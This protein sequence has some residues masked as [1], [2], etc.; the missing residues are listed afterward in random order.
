M[1]TPEE[2][3]ALDAAAKSKADPKPDLGKE[4]EALKAKNLEYENKIKEFE[5]RKVDDTDL[6]AKA[7]AERDAKDKKNSD[8]KA[9]EKA[10]TFNL[11]ADEFLKTNE[12]L[13]PKDIGDIFKLAQKENY[14]DAI[15][16]DGAIKT[17][18]IQSFFSVQANMDLLT[19]SQKTS[20]DD[21]L[22]LTKTGKQ[23][24]AQSIYDSIFEPSFE[25]L[26]RI[27]KATAL[28]KGQVE[29]GDEDLAY[30]NKM[31][32]LAKQHHLGEK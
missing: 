26:K 28:S 10:L 23:E 1:P 25:M 12:S 24:K 2:Q 8:T 29:S 6:N 27:K 15:E 4:L 22:K 3:A 20:L 30:K 7:K 11:K 9:L 18:I 14:N 31:I 5:S 16:K 19:D 21:Y 17:G 13:L 32:K